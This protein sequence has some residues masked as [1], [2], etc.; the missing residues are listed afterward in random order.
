MREYL[1]IPRHLL[2]R[3]V[4]KKVHCDWAEH[5]CHWF[6][7]RLDGDYAELCT[8]KGKKLRVRASTLQTVR[9]KENFLAHLLRK[10]AAK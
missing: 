3:W 6:L 10:E 7:T 9:D 1:Y 5:G 4:G 2:H 8:S